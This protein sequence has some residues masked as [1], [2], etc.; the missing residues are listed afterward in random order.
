[1]TIQNVFRRIALL[2]FVAPLSLSAS[3]CGD[4]D[5]HD[6]DHEGEHGEGF[7]EEFCEHL[8]NGPDVALTATDAP[9]G[10]PDA[11]AEHTRH[12]VTLPAGATGYISFAS[13]EATEFAF[14]FSTDASA[15]LFD[16]GGN[17]IAWEEV[18]TNPEGGCDALA[19]YGTADL[20]VGTYTL[21]L[22]PVDGDFVQVVIEEAAHEEGE[23]DHE[24]E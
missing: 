6:H 5:D 17:E 4:D 13:D 2:A 22:G 7:V 19:L 23:H 11:S 9:E 12:D 1:M 8:E 24:G 20:E 16:A 10:A 18:E 14:G 21:A 3:A 15:M